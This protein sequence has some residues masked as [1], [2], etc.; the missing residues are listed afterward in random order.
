MTDTYRIMSILVSL[1]LFTYQDQMC[2]SLSN[3]VRA[4]DK[5]N[6]YRSY[7][8]PM[9]WGTQRRSTF[10]S[11][12]LP[13]RGSGSNVREAAGKIYQLEKGGGDSFTNPYTGTVTV[14]DVTHMLPLNYHLAT[15][16]QCVL[17]SAC[18]SV[19]LSVCLSLSVCMCV[20]LGV[21]VCEGKLT[22]RT[23][24]VMDRQTDRQT[25]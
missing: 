6:L 22:V 13:K 20:F 3:F 24:R 23:D 18:M 2:P 4:L 9:A 5:M 11:S 8:R 7:I 12:S 25:D 14:H 15:T 21:C 10:L 17:V 16:Y 1:V 19:C